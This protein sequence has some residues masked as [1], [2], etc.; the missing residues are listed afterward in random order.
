MYYYC[1]SMFGVVISV[2]SRSTETIFRR[3]ILVSPHLRGYPEVSASMT[4]L[5]HLRPSALS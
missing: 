3:S 2:V 5:W 1:Y 4:S